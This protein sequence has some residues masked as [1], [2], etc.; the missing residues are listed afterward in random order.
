MHRQYESARSFNIF[1]R[2]NSRDLSP[3]HEK[4]PPIPMQSYTPLITGK[5]RIIPIKIEKDT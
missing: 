5:E 3:P 4:P 2:I 1:D